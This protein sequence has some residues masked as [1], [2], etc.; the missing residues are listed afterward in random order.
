[1]T[2][3]R[4]PL[5]V[6]FLIPTMV[7]LGAG[8]WFFSRPSVL[9]EKADEARPAAVSNP[10]EGTFDY[11]IVGRTHI[12]SGTPGSGYNSNPPTSGVH[13]P[14]PAKGGIYDT[15]LPDEQAIHNMEH[16]YIWIS[17]WPKSVSLQATEGAALK[18]GLSDEDLN[19]IEEIVKDDDWKIILSPREA[20][21]KKIALAAW[22]RVLNLDEF[23]SDKIKDFIKTYRN[24]GPEKTPE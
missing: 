16:G 12:A 15:A 20:N 2:L 13:W 23:D 19:K 4:V 3:S 18:E 11:D 6:W 24:R 17:Y 1:M 9:G 21:E 8:V 7:I 14:A 5:L 22:G 10:V